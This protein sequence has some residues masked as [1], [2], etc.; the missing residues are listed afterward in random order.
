MIPQHVMI[1]AE[2]VCNDFNYIFFDDEEEN[3]ERK[4]LTVEKQNSL[5][6]E[7][8]DWLT[9]EIDDIK[10]NEDNEDKKIIVLCHHAPTLKNSLDECE[11]SSN[12]RHVSGSELR[13]VYSRVDCI[14]YGHTHHTNDQMLKN[15]RI[16]SNQLG[17]V[18]Q[19]D[20]KYDVNYVI[21]PFKDSEELKY[22]IFLRFGVSN[23]YEDEYEEDYFDEDYN[24]DNNNN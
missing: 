4:K 24:N 17:Y 13:S 18:G 23:Y 7:H 5:H 16:V 1:A 2:M 9:S 21:D 8:K 12:L 3:N 14:C 20:P 11:S 10:S 15:C 22:E 6:K 19:H